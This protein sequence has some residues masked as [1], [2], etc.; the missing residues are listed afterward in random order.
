M[1]IKSS[2]CMSDEA[3]S[4]NSSFSNQ[5][6]L[7]TDES[8]NNNNTSNITVKTKKLATKSTLPAGHNTG[9]SVNTTNSNS[10]NVSN[11]TA[12]STFNYINHSSNF[13]Y[14]LQHTNTDHLNHDS[15]YVDQSSNNPN[16]GYS[17]KNILSFAA[18]QY[19]AVSNGINSN[20][21]NNTVNN[22]SNATSNYPLKR[23]SHYIQSTSSINS[24]SNWQNSQSSNLEPNSG[25]SKKTSEF[26]PASQG[27]IQNI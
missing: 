27:I 20:S 15:A 22:S 6:G 11:Q 1:D 14:N 10:T 18:Q 16:N 24:T 13:N 4:N 21:V 23:K 12:P 7:K 2:N 25:P 19:A 5:D 3:L 8:D 26:N 17:I 9:T